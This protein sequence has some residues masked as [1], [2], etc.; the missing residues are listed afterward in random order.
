[1]FCFAI[2]KAADEKAPA[3]LDRE[4]FDAAEDGQLDKLLDLCQQWA[5][6]SVIDAYTNEIVS[7]NS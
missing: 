2:S 7:V 3:G 5:G 4:I 6:H 1:L